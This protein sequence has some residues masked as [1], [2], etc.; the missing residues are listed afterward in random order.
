MKIVTVKPTNSSKRHY[1][2]VVNKIKKSLTLNIKYKKIKNF[3]G[4]N[5]YGKITIN[6]K[7]TKN[8]RLFRKIHCIKKCG[9]V[10]GVTYGFE[11]DPNR[12]SKIASVF[13]Y[14]QKQF[15]YVIASKNLKIG[16]IIK[17]GKEGQVKL[18]HCLKLQQIPI[19]CPI[20]N[21]S[22]KPNNIAKIT[23]SAGTFS[24]ILNKNK[25][26][27]NLILNSNKKKIL[28]NNCFC[29]VGIVSNEF[30]FLK[31]FGKAGR[32]RWLG[33]KPTVRG[34]AMNP[35]DHPNGGGEGKKSSKNKTPWGK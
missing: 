30:I 3:G 17:I 25:T 21:I 12:N 6:H 31:Q 28:S 23:R 14:K 33:I 19:G 2:N 24:V 5:N 4:R 8:K 22:L 35:C 10:I 11:Y 32:K 1:L 7:G 29:Y 18:A 16:D 15:F 20:Y 34:V 9:T 27:V 26:T 13:N